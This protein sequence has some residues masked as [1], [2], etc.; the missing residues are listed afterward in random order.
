MKSTKFLRVNGIDCNGKRVYFEDVPCGT[1]KSEIIDRFSD[2]VIL[3][4]DLYNEQLRLR[5]AKN[6]QIIRL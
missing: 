4:V 6:I 2:C 3:S 1:K 5:I